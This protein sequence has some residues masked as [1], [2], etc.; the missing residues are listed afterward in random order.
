[1]ELMTE[2]RYRVWCLSQGGAPEAPVTGDAGDDRRLADRMRSLARLHRHNAHDLRSPLNAMVV[3]LELLGDAVEPGASGGD[4]EARRRRYVGV[5]KEELG[6]LS[7]HLAAWLAHTAPPDAAMRDFDAVPLVEELALVLEPRTRKQGTELELD[8]PPEPVEAHGPRDRVRQLLLA[9]AVRALDDLAGDEG[10]PVTGDR[11]PGDGGVL[12]IGVDDAGGS[13]RLWMA[14]DGPAT[15]AAA[16]RRIVETHRGEDPT[17]R[18]ESAA[19]CSGTLT[20]TSEPGEGTRFEL[21]L[22]PRGAEGA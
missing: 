14:H 21:T 5:L 6:R 11:P 3:N 16:V 19:H 22:P 17:D 4:L 18:P 7:R 20:V 2:T 1:M 12:E 15:A 9:L 8:L 13:A 10:A